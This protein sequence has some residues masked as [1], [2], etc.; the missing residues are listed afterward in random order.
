MDAKRKVGSPKEAWQT[1]RAEYT[2]YLR[3]PFKGDFDR[4]HW[5][6]GT[7]AD[8]LQPIA[9]LYELA[10]RHPRIGQL[11]SK[12]LDAGW[13]GQEL[14]D[15]P[16]GAATR[17]MESK[18]FEDLGREPNAVHCLCL[19]GLKSWP[20]LGWRNQE[21]WEMSAGI[22]KGIDC[23]HPVE[24]CS[25]VTSSALCDVILQR[26]RALKL[27]K[28]ASQFWVGKVEG[29][30][31][32]AVVPVHPRKLQK[33]IETVVKHL[34][35]KPISDGEIEAA[36]AASAVSAHRQ[37]RWLFAVAPD[38]THERA[39]HLLAE[40]YREEQ[41]RYGHSK[42]RGRW[43]DWLPVIAAFEEAEDQQ[44]G[45]KSQ[46]FTAYRRVMDNVQFTPKAWTGL[47]TSKPY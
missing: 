36:V 10:R 5:W 11:R 20:T 8:A 45:A 26:Q 34:V 42:N 46:I 32:D 25:S 18:A 44:R 41:R 31:K 15:S 37:G 28:G 22:L 19:I 39:A 29:S 40:T 47:L 16:A 30:N 38:L 35:E 33:S 24:Q 12:L 4:T 1:I 13:H 43:E 2:W 3:P 7:T 27:P 6:K 14:R 21:Y 23:R 17:R 9:A